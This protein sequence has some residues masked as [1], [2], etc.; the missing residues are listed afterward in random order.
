MCNTADIIIMR[1]G[2]VQSATTVDWEQPR[3]NPESSGG[4][5]GGGGGFKL[6]RDHRIQV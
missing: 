6:N 5:G 3:K 4:G 2:Y 1:Y